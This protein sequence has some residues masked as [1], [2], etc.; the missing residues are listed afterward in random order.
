[1]SNEISSHESGNKILVLVLSW[2]GILI[3]SVLIIL[4]QVL[5]QLA[6]TFWKDLLFGMGLALA[7]SG[8]IGLIGDY[9]VFGRTMEMLHGSNERLEVQIERLNVSTEFLKQSSDLGLE[10]IYPDRKSALEFFAPLMREQ[11]KMKGRKGEL[12]IVGSSVKGLREAIRNLEDIIRDASENEDCVF[13]ILLTHPEYCRF[14]EN[15]EERPTGAIEEEIFQTMLLLEEYWAKNPTE[16]KSIEQNV[17]LYKGTPTCFMIIAGD[18]MLINPYPYEKEAYKSFCLLVKEPSIPKE[19]EEIPR[20]IYQQFYRDHFEFPWKRNALQYMHFLLEGP[21]PDEA[22][23]RRKR[24]GDV[25]VVQDSG[26]FHL[27]VVLSGEKN[28]EVRGIP[29]SVPYEKGEGDTIK[30]LQLGDEFSV[31]LLPVTSDVSSTDDKWI[32]LDSEKFKRGRLKLD[33]DRR[34]GKFSC[35][36][37]GS[38]V[39]E[40]QMIGLFDPAH[41]SP[42][43]HAMF[44]KRKDLQD[45]PLPLFWYWIKEKP[46]M[47]LPQVEHSQ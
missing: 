27:I 13:Q 32:C 11:S 46:E 20:S 12:I 2:S 35:E 47:P 38:L 40:Y 21:I 29:P 5:T 16:G 9:L 10:M 30:T 17:K 31:R 28:A 7:P 19:S 26:K 6:A 1:M 24:Y 8:V 36:I 15:Q 23:D 25:F 43:T 4:S 45:K 39:N 33:R 37:E 41:P 42:F 14:R 34:S 18:R 22:W 44:A 3:G